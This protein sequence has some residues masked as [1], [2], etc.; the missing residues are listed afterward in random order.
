MLIESSLSGL[1][2]L[3]SKTKRMRGGEAWQEHLV[4]A[5]NIKIKFY[6]HLAQLGEQSVHNR[7]VLGSNPR[8]SMKTEILINKRAWKQAL[9]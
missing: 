5:Y 2:F 3:Y 7:S 1:L 6:G 4:V 9:F 8:M